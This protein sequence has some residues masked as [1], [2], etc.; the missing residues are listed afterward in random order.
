MAFQREIE[1]GGL[2]AC[3]WVQPTVKSFV[4]HKQNCSLIE[5]MLTPVCCVVCAWVIEDSFAMDELYSPRFI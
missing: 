5:A 2:F 4:L 1:F 3:Q